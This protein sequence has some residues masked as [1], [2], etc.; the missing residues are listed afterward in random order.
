MYEDNHLVIV[1]KR[2]S[3]ISQGDQ[4]GDMSLDR[5]MKEFIKQRDHKPG[6][7]FMG[8]PHRLDRPVSGVESWPRPARH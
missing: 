7:V 1:N 8:I 5:L 2:S 6:E 4:T 3:D